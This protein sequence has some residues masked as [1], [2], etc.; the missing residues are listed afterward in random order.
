MT[1]AG[2][3]GAVQVM[4][5]GMFDT[6]RGLPVG[7]DA[8]FAL[9][10]NVFDEAASPYLADS[11]ALQAAASGV[12]PVA[13]TSPDDFAESNL[14][15]SI[16]GYVFCGGPPPAVERGA[17]VRL[18]LLAAGSEEGMHGPVLDGVPLTAAGRPVGVPGLMP[19][20]ARIVEFRA[21]STGAWPLYCAVTD[22]IAAGMRSRIIVGA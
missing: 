12:T 22:H 14:M 19:F 20:T 21:E 17:R 4:R 15:H 11:I 9:L 10:F 5:P 18:L 2:L 7:V 16:N 8:Q 13:A 3:I 1:H 6:A